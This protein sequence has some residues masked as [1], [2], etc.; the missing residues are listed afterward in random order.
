MASFLREPFQFQNLKSCFI[1]SF[2]FSH[3]PFMIFKTGE[4]YCFKKILKDIL[5]FLFSLN[6]ELELG[7]LWVVGFFVVSFFFCDMPCYLPDQ[8]MF[9]SLFAC[10][11]LKNIYTVK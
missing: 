4:E 2:L 6:E 7:T 1:L 11:L 5:L 3:V 10:T 9:S 8:L